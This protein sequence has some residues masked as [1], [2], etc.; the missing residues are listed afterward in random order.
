[1]STVTHPVAAGVAKLREIRDRVILIALDRY[2]TAEMRRAAFL[3][4]RDNA[5][6]HIGASG[7]LRFLKESAT[8]WEV[9]LAEQSG[10]PDDR[11][12]AAEMLTLERAALSPSAR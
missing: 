8:G 12:W 11:T 5:C 4:G 7:I 6:H 2:A 9:G 10:S 1:M 3:I